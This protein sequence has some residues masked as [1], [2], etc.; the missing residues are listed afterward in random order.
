MLFVS[1]KIT[2]KVLHQGNCQ[3]SVPVTLT[4]FHEFTSAALTSYFA[5]KINGAE[6]LKYFNTWPFFL[7]LK[8]SFQI[9]LWALRQNKMT[10]SQNFV[11][12]LQIGIKIDVMRGSLHLNNSLSPCQLSRLIKTF[13][14]PNKSYWIFNWWCV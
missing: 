13:N 10:G 7:I 1:P 5:E 9:T 12:H 2:H 6:L 3:Q 14:E 8:F 4:N 11:V